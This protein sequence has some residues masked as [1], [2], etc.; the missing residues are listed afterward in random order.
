MDGNTYA[1][2]KWFVLDLNQQSEERAPVLSEGRES[3]AAAPFVLPNTLVEV[4]RTR[5]DCCGC[6]ACL[7]GCCSRREEQR[8]VEGV[9]S[10]IGGTPILG[11]VAFVVVLVAVVLIVVLVWS[12][13]GYEDKD[14]SG[15]GGLIEDLYGSGSVR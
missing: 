13:E 4:E 7:A 6:C 3:T 8:A 11:A 5:G 12:L 15:S 14:E 1:Q 10:G 2:R 9:G